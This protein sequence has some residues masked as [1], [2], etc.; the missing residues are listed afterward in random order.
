LAEKAQQ[1]AIEAAMH[2]SSQEEAEAILR[3]MQA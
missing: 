3:K 1:M 2:A